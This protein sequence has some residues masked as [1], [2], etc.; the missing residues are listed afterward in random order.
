MDE[1]A[2]REAKRKERDEQHLYI[3]MRVI[4]N[5]T[6]E[7]HTGFDL[8]NFEASPDADPAAP[9]IYRILR[10]ATVE[11]AIATIAEDLSQDPKKVRLWLMVNRQNKTIRPDQPIMDVHLS[12]EETYTRISSHRDNMLRV[13]AEV[14][15]EVGPDGEPIWPSFQS[16]PNGQVT[17][18]DLILLFLKYFDV[19]NQTI[20]GAGHVYLNKERKVEDLLQVIMKK[21]GWG[22]NLPEGDRLTLWEVS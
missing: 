17:K 3:G 12:V 20:T 5:S 21:M 18:N 22:E 8:T 9:R 14:A 15:E 1:L 16:Q 7:H 19:E 6:F 13:W 11:E 4:T 10:T 2:A